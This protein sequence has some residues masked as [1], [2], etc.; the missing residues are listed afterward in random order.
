[1]DT[2]KNLTP[3]NCDTPLDRRH[4]LKTST[5]ATA[6]AAILPAGIVS[7][8]LAATQTKLPRAETL[9]KTLYNSLSRSQRS[10][11]C[12]DFDHRLRHEIDNNWF[13]V[14]DHRVRSYTKDQQAM[15]REIFMKMHSEEYADQVMKQVLDDSGRDGFGECSIALFGKPDTGKFQFVLTGRHTT[16]RCDGDSVEGTAFGGP[17]FYGHAAQSFNEKPHHPGNVYWFQAKRANEVFQMMDGKQR[18]MALMDWSRD[19]QGKKTIALTGKKEGLDGIRMTELASDQKEEV[20]NVLN[21]LLLPF[22]KEDR[23]ESLKLIEKSGFDNLHLAFY[24]GEDI[25]SD[26][27]WDVFQ[28]EGPNMIWYFRGDPHVH[29]WVHIKDHV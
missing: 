10:N 9:V 15:I 2:P 28:V 11:V 17:I 13:I 4:F 19:E 16:R 1:M 7:Q 22:R 18:E 20:R 29:T 3:C 25:G 12:F 26:G 27:V 14:K 6:G 5:L 23:Q 8:S 21:D 24:K